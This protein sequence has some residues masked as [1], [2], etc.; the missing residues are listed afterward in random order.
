MSAANSP[1]L[2]PN[3][4]LRLVAEPGRNTGAL[5]LECETVAEADRFFVHL[6][7]HMFPP[8]ERGSTTFAVQAGDPGIFL[9]E[10]R[11]SSGSAKISL[12]GVTAEI[13]NFVRS[14][15]EERG[16]ILMAFAGRDGGRMTILNPLENHIVRAYAIVDGE[17]VTG[18]GKTN[19]NDFLK[20]MKE[21]FPC[22]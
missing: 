19:W 5:V 1:E 20:M 18:D 15:I 12:A 4:S 2:A 16:S 11:S 9:F 7:E 13:S 6:V 14:T 10:A 22:T 3:F 17:F 21:S 8:A